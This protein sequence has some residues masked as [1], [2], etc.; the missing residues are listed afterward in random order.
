MDALF[1]WN[2][3]SHFLRDS[4]VPL[5][6]GPE[7]SP[8]ANRCHAFTR[9]LYR[10]IYYLEAP[11]N[12]YQ[13]SGYLFVSSSTERRWQVIEDVHLGEPEAA[14]AMD[15]QELLNRRVTMHMVEG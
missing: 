2:C 15:C 14:P 9:S 6:D 3:V 4:C 8:S 11:R 10:L 5:I 7:G 13:E 1:A 12:F